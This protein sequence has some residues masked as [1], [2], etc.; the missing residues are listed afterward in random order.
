MTASCNSCA[1]TQDLQVVAADTVD[2]VVF[3][4]RVTKGT[5]SALP[6]WFWSCKRC[7]WRSIAEFHRRGADVHTHPPWLRPCPSRCVTRLGGRHAQ[8]AVLDATGRDPNESYRLAKWFDGL[9]TEGTL[10]INA[11]RVVRFCGLGRRQQF[12]EPLTSFEAIEAVL[13]WNRALS[14][15]HVPLWNLFFPLISF[16]C[17]E[18]ARNAPGGALSLPDPSDREIQH[19][20]VALWDLAPDGG[21][22]FRNSWGIGWGNR[23]FGSMTREYFDRFWIEAWVGRDCA[24][25]LS[26]FSWDR[27]AGAATAGE[28]HRSWM[29][30][31]PVWTKWVRW[32]GRR[33]RILNFETLSIDT[34]SPVDVIEIRNG[35]GLRVGWVHLHHRGEL[36]SSTVTEAR[37]LF[38]WPTFRRQGFGTLLDELAT[39]VAL[40]RRSEVLR[41]MCHE[42]DFHVAVRRAGREFLGASE[43]R[44]RWR[45]ASHPRLVASADKALS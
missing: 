16:R 11:A 34:E 5:E 42:A 43:Y 17:F 12:Y 24:V 29:L 10:P 27:I 23:G 15:A 8:V 9:R 19:H 22:V 37:E 26:R 30:R 4:F 28:R 44:I 3:L 25:G 14:A 32:R 41:V 20:C 39:E 31:N 45:R 33:V 7:Y 13:K 36:E 35:Y 40:A 6:A 38:V 18:S 2:E 21:L 1:A